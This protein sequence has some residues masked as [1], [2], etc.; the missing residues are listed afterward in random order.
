MADLA[1]PDLVFVP[2]GPGPLSLL[3][4]EAILDWLREAHRHSRLTTSV[5]TGSLLLGAAGIL[6]G[7]AGEGVAGGLLAVR[8]D[9][10]RR[11]EMHVIG[12]QL[13]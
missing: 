13:E 8:R 11:R 7:N 12:E 3:E 4:D 2:G 6:E 10:Q 5:C 9:E 1:D